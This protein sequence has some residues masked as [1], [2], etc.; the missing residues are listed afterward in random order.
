[1]ANIS[2]KHPGAQTQS[3]RISSNAGTQDTG[4]GKIQI[5]DDVIASVVRKYTLSVPGVAR[6]VGQSIV[7]GLAGIIGKK[8]QDRAIRVDMEG[9]HVNIT[10]NV[11]V[12]FGEHVPT[13]AT[14]IQNV[15]RKYIEELTGQQVDQVNVIVQNLEE[16]DEEELLDEEYEEDED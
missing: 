5:S 11:V 4:M 10:V 2:R 8:V 16:E 9:E 1:M 3:L 6:L 15:C 14:N 12:R 13:V 7:G